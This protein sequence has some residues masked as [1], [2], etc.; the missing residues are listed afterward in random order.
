ML[1]STDA[2]PGDGAQFDAFISVLTFCNSLHKLLRVKTLKRS[3]ADLDEIRLGETPHGAAQRFCWTGTLS[4]KATCVVRKREIRKLRGEQEE[5]DRTE[6]FQ[7]F[8]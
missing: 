8:C 7:Q 6:D 1:R 3:S 4:D 2:E 5:R